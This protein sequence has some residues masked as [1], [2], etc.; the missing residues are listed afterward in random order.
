MPDAQFAA[1]Y[2]AAAAECVR[3]AVEDGRRVRF[4]PRTAFRDAGPPSA[5]RAW[6]SQ[7]TRD[8]TST[9]TPRNS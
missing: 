9:T 1:E 7:I 8:L 2:T 6:L 3:L 4:P 5:R